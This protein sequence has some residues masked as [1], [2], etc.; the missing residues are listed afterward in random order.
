MNPEQ[1]FGD[2]LASSRRTAVQVGGGSVTDFA[3]LSCLGLVTLFTAWRLMGGG[4]LIGQ[5]SATQFYPWYSF[6]GERL[7]DFDL[8]S[9]NPAQ[10]SGAPFIGDPQSGWTYLPAMLLFTLFPLAAAAPLY[11]FFHLALAGFGAYGLGRA[12]GFGPV[13]A[14]TTGLAYELSGPIFAR[15][16]CCPAQIQVSAWVPILLLGAELAIRRR[17]AWHTWLPWAMLSG[18]ALSQIIAS[19]LGQGSYY[20]ILLLGSFV[21]YRTLIGRVND[22]DESLRRRFTTMVT[23]LGT[24]GL[25]GVGL[26]AAGILPRLEYNALSNLAGGVYP[27]DYAYAAV[28][29]G[30]SAGETVFRDAISHPYYPGGIVAALATM[31]VVLAKGRFASPYFTTLVLTGFILSSEQTTLVHRFFYLVFPRFEDF[32]V[33][34]PERVGMVAYIGIAML[35]GAAVHSLPAWAGRLKYLAAIAAIPV[36]VTAAF[37]IGLRPS[38]DALPGVVIGGVAIVVVVLAIV[39]SWRMRSA[40]ALAPIVLVI[41]AALDLVAAHAAMVRNGPYGG[42]HEVNLAAYYDTTGAIRFLQR[43]TGDEAGRYYG[44]NP[45]LRFSEEGVPI[46]YRYQFASDATKQIAVNNRAT[47]YGLR[48]IQGYNPIQYQ[49]YVEFIT[50]INGE[51]QDYH[52]SN[53]WAAGNSSP[54]LDLL[55]VRY[56]IIPSDAAESR[57]DLNELLAMHP[58]VYQDDE[59]RVLK[60]QSALPRAW[61][62]HEA[63]EAAGARARDLVSEGLIDPQ[64]TAAVDGLLPSLE[65]APSGAVERVQIVAEEAEKIALSVTAA[66]DGLLVLSELA[67]PAW[68]ATID[69]EPVEQLTAF[70]LLRAIPVDAGEHSIVFEYQSRMEQAGLA[71]SSMAVFAV[72]GG[73]TAAWIRRRRPSAP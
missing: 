42:F 68:K 55:N 62:V 21:L 48:D 25:A 20:A 27:E 30:W 58:T 34:W 43:Q 60:R 17:S 59:V 14:V 61:L 16:V 51:P 38:G 10:F 32:H 44:Y 26:A 73:L 3:A 6:L 39:G 72:A 36:A 18:L 66:S 64:K 4:F 5:D 65:P 49:K 40:W 52:D 7:R 12:I 13:G 9:W 41:F 2:E 24:I 31:A 1:T 15:S 37:A 70:G 29:G 56:V 54:L 63:V 28:T 46:L 33:H 22:V 69:G 47:I 8:P 35:A 50:A 11:I 53:I 23:L 45:A 19:W 57:D 71:L 67:Y